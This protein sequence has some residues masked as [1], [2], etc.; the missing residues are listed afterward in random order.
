MIEPCDL[1]ELEARC[2][3]FRRAK[4]ALDRGATDDELRAL[5]ERPPPWP[6]LLD[7]QA[8]AEGRAPGG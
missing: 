3:V 2:A 5:Q 1:R 6:D 4:H 8:P 7:V